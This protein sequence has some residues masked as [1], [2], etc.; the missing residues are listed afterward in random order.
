MMIGSGRRYKDDGGKFLFFLCFPSLLNSFIT[1]ARAIIP[2]AHHITL[3]FFAPRV[4]DEEWSLMLIDKIV[5]R[6]CV[7][8]HRKK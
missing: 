8:L 1:R 7:V 6:S 3:L 4:R 5:I 2:R